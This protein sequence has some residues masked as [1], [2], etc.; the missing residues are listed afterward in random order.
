ML[1]L[2]RVTGKNAIGSKSGSKEKRIDVE[3]TIVK[4][5]QP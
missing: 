5:L 1:V 2:G 3:E 4:L